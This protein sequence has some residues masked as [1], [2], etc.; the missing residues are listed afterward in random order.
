MSFAVV[1]RTRSGDNDKD[2]PAW[3]DRRTAWDSLV[4]SLDGVPGARVTVVAD[5]GVPA[6]LRGVV[7]G[8]AEVV[9]V[10]AGMTARSFRRAVEVGC[11]LA[12]DLPPDAVV[13][14]AEDDYLYTPEALAAVV[15]AASEVPA[16]DY[17]SVFT[18]DDTAWHD[19][20]PSQPDRR[21]DGLPGGPVTVGDHVWDRSAK[22]TSTFGVRAGVLLADR[23]LL[24]LGSRVG[25]P[26]DTATWHALQGLRPFPVRHLLSDLAPAPSVRG[27]VKVVGKPLMRAVLDVVVAV[28]RPRRVLL[29]TQRQ[30]AVHM[31]T[32]QLPADPCWPELAARVADT[33]APR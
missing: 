17:F 33:R 5:G 27:V 6:D 31:E 14:F 10:S 4:A 30:L 29:A 28:R 22:T 18:P 7:E 20:H 8:R 15:R 21:V 12:R 19:T 9:A 11:R 23:W 13:W 1:Y 2:R 3:Y 16:A 32:A 26:F 25:A 24:E